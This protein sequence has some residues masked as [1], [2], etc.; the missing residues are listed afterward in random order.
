MRTQ[1]FSKLGV[2]L[3]IVVGLL[4]SQAQADDLVERGAKLFA[5][6]TFRGNGRTCQTC[7]TKETGALSIQQVSLLPSHD[8]LFQH[9]A[10]D[11][12]GGNTFSRVRENATFL[13]EIDLPQNVSIAGS[14]SRVAVLARGVPP[15]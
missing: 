7:H 6:A 14:A 13:V 11:V 8:V 10:A 5:G 3:G 15:V 4:F 9:D 2:S 1:L 12:M